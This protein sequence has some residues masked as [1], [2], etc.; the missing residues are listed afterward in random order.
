ML[1]IRNVCLFPIGLFARLYDHFHAP[2]PNLGVKPRLL[3]RRY[4]PRSFRLIRRLLIFD[5]CL[6]H[7]EGSSA[8]ACGEIRRRPQAGSKA[9]FEPSQR[10]LSDHSAR[11]ALEAIDE[12]RNGNNGRIVHQ[13]VDM[14]SFAVH[15]DKLCIEILA[16]ALKDVFEESKLVC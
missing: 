15:F 8:A 16:D 7:R 5:V 14:I 4:K 9:S 6:N 12:L 13:Q 1:R 3:G 10:L 2:L 11:N